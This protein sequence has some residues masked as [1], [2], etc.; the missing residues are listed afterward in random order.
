MKLIAAC[1][2]FSNSFGLGFWVWVF[3]IGFS[4]VF[5]VDLSLLESR[6]NSSAEYYEIITKD[7]VTRDFGLISSTAIDAGAT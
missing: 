4:L 1:L 3:T 5:G 2:A 7:L 6:V